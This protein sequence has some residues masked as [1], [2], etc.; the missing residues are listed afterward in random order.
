VTL[1]RRLVCAF[2]VL[3]TVVGACQSGV[4]V[5]PKLAKDQVL[6]LMLD[7]QPATLDPG[8]TQYTYETAVLRAIVDN[9]SV[10]DAVVEVRDARLPLATA[11][12]GLHPSLARKR[13]V[14]AL[15]REDL[16]DPDVTDRWLALLARSGSEVFATTGTHASSLKTLRTALLAKR[17]PDGCLRIAVVGGGPA[18]LYFASLWKTRHPASTI[19]LFEQLG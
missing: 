17:P 5:G 4:T 10:I 16:A 14:I 11:A 12:T 1:S 8:Q 9:A 3:L 18:G 7:D 15:N 13:R 19:E 6:R 2:A